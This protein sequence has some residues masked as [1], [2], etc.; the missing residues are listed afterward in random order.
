MIAKAFMAISEKQP[1]CIV[2][3]SGVSDSSCIDKDN[4]IREKKLLINELENSKN[5]LPFIYFST[6]SIYDEQ[7]SNSPYVIHKKNMEEIVYKY[8][9]GIVFRLPQI[10]GPNSPPKT[11]LQTIRTSL[12]NAKPLEIWTKAKRNILD[13]KDARDIIIHLLN[14]QNIDF[15][16]LNIANKRSHSMIEIVKT[17]EKVLDKKIHKIFLNKGSQYNID[18]SYIDQ[19]IEFQKLNDNEYLDRIILRYYI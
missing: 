10:A 2:F 7:L 19:L 16:C 8:S 18:V 13:I 6:C 12:I 9:N 5:D 15:K 17:F 11:L 14:K 4:F 3:A 1:N